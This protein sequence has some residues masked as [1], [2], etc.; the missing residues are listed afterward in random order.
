MSQKAEKMDATH[1]QF[2]VMRLR[3]LRAEEKKKPPIER[4]PA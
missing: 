3:P 1:K 4:V 2:A